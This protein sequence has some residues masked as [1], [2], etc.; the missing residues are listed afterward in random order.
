MVRIK[1]NPEKIR[2]IRVEKRENFFIKIIYHE[3]ESACKG[4]RGK[5]V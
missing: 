4:H 5:A 3:K 1:N 2:I